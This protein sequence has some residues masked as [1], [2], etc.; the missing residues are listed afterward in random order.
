MRRMLTYNILKIYE[1]ISNV[2]VYRLSIKIDM[3]EFSDLTWLTMVY[4]LYKSF[5]PNPLTRCITTY[6]P[7]AASWAKISFFAGSVMQNLLR[8]KYIRILC[9]K[10]RSTLN[11]IYT[12]ILISF[13]SYENCRSRAGVTLENQPWKFNFAYK[14][15]CLQIR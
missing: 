13:D 10:L 5:H 15:I 14:N 2:R 4:I 1:S 6:T 11:V 7:H 3:N 9:L 8:Y 12:L